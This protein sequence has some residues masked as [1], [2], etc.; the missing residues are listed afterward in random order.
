MVAQCAMIES[1]MAA[2]DYEYDVFFSYKRHKLTLG[3]TREVHRRLQ[4]WLTQEVGREIRMFVDEDSIETGERWPERLRES[5]KL[6]RCMVCIWSAPY[7]LSD[8]CLSE[9]ASFRER[10]KR[11]NM[12]SHGLIAPI[13]FHDGEHFPPEAREVEWTDF[14]P[15]AF[16]VPAFWTSSK[17]Q[18]LEELLKEELVRSVA[19]IIKSAPPFDPD[20]PVVEVPAGGSA[21]I[22]LARL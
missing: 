6:S 3:W 21:K 18:E 1:R 16:T 11:L 7:F 4:F 14:S 12:T 19:K 13:R 15:Y 10:E 8:W 17:A 5:L 20:W 2:Q 9:W 22:E